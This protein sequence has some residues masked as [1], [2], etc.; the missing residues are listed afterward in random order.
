MDILS[1]I[2]ETIQL[3]GVF[4]FS[5]ALAGEFGVTVPAYR[6]VA[7]F[8]IA[9]E[10]R[11]YVEVEGH[12]PIALNPGDVILIPR[13]AQHILSDAPC[14]TAPPL[15]TVLEQV[16]Y[17]G[18]GLLAVGD[19]SA[20]AA[21]LVCGHLSFVEGADHRVLRALPPYIL[22]TPRTRAQRPWLDEAIRVLVQNVFSGHPGAFATVKRMSE[23]MF[24]EAV[25]AAADETPELAGLISGFADPQ[26][27]RAL[28]LIHA[29]PE[30]DWTV[31][32]L[33]KAVAMS[34]SRFAERFQALL[35]TGPMSYLAEWRLQR[36]LVLL[37]TT[38]QSIGQ[39]ARATGYRSP[40]S[41][42]RAFT[43]HF[44]H[45]P[46]DHRRSQGAE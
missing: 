21:R 39:I 16:G 41:F 44:G 20:D 17:S 43:A 10:G 46:R 32:G 33:A 27:G 2:F 14:R 12:A 40:N 6:H 7:R 23:V 15:E 5:T 22:I 38:P 1:D 18:S 34:R 31:A 13:G 11:C 30:E 36:A 9:V 37:S 35:G 3:K 29:R 25:A 4:Y 24:I 19:P 8:H 45:S 26:I 42:T 28:D